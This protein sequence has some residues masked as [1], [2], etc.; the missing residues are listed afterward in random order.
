MLQH[1]IILQS[2]NPRG[3]ASLN[4]NVTI[5]GNLS[6][7]SGTLDIANLT[8]NRSPAGGTFTL[9]AGT[10]LRLS[11]SN[12]FPANYSSY[13]LNSASTV[14]YY[15]AGTQT[16]SA[17]T[18]GNLT[19]TNGGANAKSLS[20]ATV[21]ASELL[22]NSGATL[23]GGALTLNV[24][25]NW[26]NNGSFNAGAGTVTLSG[27]SKSLTGTTTF[28]NLTVTGSCTA[29]SDITVN[30]LMNISGGTYAAGSTTTTFSGNFSNTGSFTSS[31]TVTFSGTSAQI[32]TL[33]VGFT[34]TGTTNF[35]GTV[36]PS[37]NSTTSPTFAILNINNSGGVSP[38]RAWNITGAFTVANGATF[39]GGSATHTFS[40]SFTNNGTVTSA[41]GTLR[42]TPTS[43]VTITLRGTTFSSTGTGTV[44]F[45]GSGLITV[46]GTP[47][48][49]TNIL[50]SNTN[51]SGVT[52]ATAWTLGGNLTINNG[53]VFN[54]GSALSHSITGDIQNNGTLNGGTS[55]ITMNGAGRFISGTGTT[56]FNNLFISGSITANSNYNFTGNFTDNGTYLE[57]GGLTVTS[58]G[59]SGSIIEGTTS[60]I[61]FE[62]LV[63]NKTSATTTL[64]A[65]LGTLTALTIQ[66]GTL[67]ASTYT[68]TEDAGNGT[69]TMA[70]GT[71]VQIG[72]NSDVP[73]FT[74]YNLN[75]AST[76]EFN[77]TGAQTIPVFNYSN[78]KISGVRTGNVTLD[79]SGTIGIA[80]MF[81][82]T[83]TFTSGGYVIAGSTVD[84]NG[85][86][87]QTI[88]SHL[89]I[90][91]LP[92]AIMVVNRLHL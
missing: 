88:G 40:G 10:T 62:T 48:T 28:N 49:L 74:D 39:N 23:S 36:A 73:V 11:G 4:G 66:S 20:G 47:T 57:G 8:A 34:T 21:C 24:Q 82:A 78:L 50:I 59:S 85:T 63:I 55:T 68:I 87:T 26:T 37:F 29:S 22:I 92:S 27:S 43:P 91:I 14:E 71:T 65:D 60:P 77:G 2:I 45:G 84:Y 53:S 86:G 30:A 9:S 61:S 75:I 41:D 25:G 17:L 16:I 76:I 18:Y 89:I 31:G 67:D 56:T 33:N 81:T 58:T 44:E 32:I 46:S 54:G 19:L 51:V 38:T 64:F 52:P 12:N 72:G 35:N 79:N 1:L 6:V 83:A 80:G 3:Y 70:A 15:G 7:S 42:F 13:L 90:T 5:S 69:L